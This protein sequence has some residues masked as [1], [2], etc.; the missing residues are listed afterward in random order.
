[1]DLGLGLP[2]VGEFA[3]P[4]RLRA[5][6]AVAE[7]AG[8]ASLWVFD[9]LLDPVATL[10]TVAAV[11]DRVR[12]GTNALL[13]PTYWP[14]SVA[15]S[16]ESLEVMSG[17]RFTLGLTLDWSADDQAASGLDHSRLGGV[18]DEVVERIARLRQGRSRI[19][20]VLAAS[21]S[22]GMDRVA[23]NGDGWTPIGIPFDRIGPLWMQIRRRAEGYGRDP[24]S[25]R[26]VLR[27]LVEVNSETGTIDRP[28]FVGSLDD[29]R[30]DLERARQVGADEVV[31]DLQAS[32]AT[33]PELLDLATCLP[34]CP[35][36]VG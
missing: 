28:A 31:L 9:R 35:V 4:E 6:A 30:E 13:P 19:P 33:L 17:G 26:L 11:T 29:I 34:R 3:H 5:V 7:E 32:A 2:Q 23:R 1:M 36:L 16:A 8:Y 10:A 25:M 15:R 12:I 18:V 14:A 24:E 20:I 21:T 27:A 22:A